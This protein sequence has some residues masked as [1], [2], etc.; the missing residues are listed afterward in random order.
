MVAKLSGQGG[1]YMHQDK[2]ASIID[3]KISSPLAAQ[4]A[5][6]APVAAA[7]ATTPSTIF[8]IRDHVERD[9]MNKI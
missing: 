6:A 1:G 3:R 2:P 7:A 9:F 4:A 5:K 8:P